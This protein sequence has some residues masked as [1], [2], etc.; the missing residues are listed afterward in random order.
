M[1]DIKNESSCEI[2]QDLLPLYQDKVCSE[3]SR[4]LVEEHLKTCTSCNEILKALEAD[5]AEE[6]FKVDAKGILNRHAKKEKTVAM[7]TGLVIAG[8]LI[9]PVII[10]LIMTMS[11][12]SDLRTDAVLIASMLLVAGITVVPLLS[13]EKKF[14]KTIIFSTVALLLIIFFVEMLF[15]DGGWIRF[16]EIALSVVFGLSVAFSPFIIMQADLPETLKYHKGLIT[17]SWD[18]IWFYLMIFIFAI[19]YPNSARELIGVSTFFV[20]LVWLGFLSI[21]YLKINGFIRAG[22]VVALIG[23]WAAIGNHIGWITIYDMDLHIEIL[24]VSL[25][26]AA[27]LAVIGIIITIVK[28]K[29]KA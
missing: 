21:R 19:A 14:S 20:A 7:K 1:N 8:I 16:G 5:E 26:A 6:K 9:L 27:L 13:K 28:R 29:N 10:A 17:M 25:M 23:I 18:T 24:F 22:L 2:I 3:K 12:Y 15:D 11:G 4:I